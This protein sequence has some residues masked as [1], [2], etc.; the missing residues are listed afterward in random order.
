MTLPMW[1]VYVLAPFTALGVLCSV[2]MLFGLS[3]IY[4]EFKTKPP[5]I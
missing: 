5:I 3:F 1:A 2:F 4:L